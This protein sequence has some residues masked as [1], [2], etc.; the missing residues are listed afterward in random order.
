MDSKLQEKS[1]VNSPD[2]PALKS[3]V[4]APTFIEQYLQDNDTQIIP[5]ATI[6]NAHIPAES[7]L[8]TVSLRDLAERKNNTETTVLSALPHTA[9]LDKNEIEELIYKNERKARRRLFKA[10]L[11]LF[12]LVAII[13]GT[14]TIIALTMF[15]KEII[16]PSPNQKTTPIEVPKTDK[17]Q[18]PPPQQPSPKKNNTN[19]QIPE[20]RTTPEEK[21]EQNNKTKTPST[22]EKPAIDKDKTTDNTDNSNQVGDSTKP[23]PS[24]DTNKD[25]T[26]N[27]N[28]EKPNP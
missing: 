26:T 23:A 27:T 8:E 9:D 6:S 14:M 10:A 21:S 11:T 25:D 1:T 12:L 4:E 7:P 2:L 5:N 17:S 3:I 16:T 24:N 28:K 19:Q 13:G 22:P 15:S 18:T 20:D